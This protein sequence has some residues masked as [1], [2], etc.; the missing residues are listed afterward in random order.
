MAPRQELHLSLCKFPSTSLNEQTSNISREG[1]HLYICARF[2]ST[3]VE[4]LFPG[5]ADGCER[6]AV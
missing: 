3:Y 1:D 6:L 5:V 4:V 2:T